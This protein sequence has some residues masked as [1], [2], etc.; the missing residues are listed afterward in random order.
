MKKTE[1]AAFR[2]MVFSAIV[3]SMLVLLSAPQRGHASPSRNSRFSDES[4]RISRTIAR[5]LNLRP[6]QQKKVMYILEKER[7]STENSRVQLETMLKRIEI[8]NFRI[9]DRMKDRIEKLTSDLIYSNYRT[10]NN[11]YS[12]LGRQQKKIFSVKMRNSFDTE[13]YSR[14]FREMKKYMSRNKDRIERF[15]NSDKAVMAMIVKENFSLDRAKNR[16][17]IQ[18]RILVHMMIKTRN[19]RFLEHYVNNIW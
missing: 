5:D 18:A 6:V 17:D 4:Y 10:R 3:L 13:K 19:T 8:N 15:R 16:C 11:I 1:N 9:P 14:S 12:I 2:S 7:R